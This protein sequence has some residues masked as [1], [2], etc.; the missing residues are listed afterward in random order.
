MYKMWIKQNIYS[1]SVD[2]STEIL[3]LFS[4]LIVIKCF[5]YILRVPVPY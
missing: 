1:F 2:R 5:K 4:A 3:Q